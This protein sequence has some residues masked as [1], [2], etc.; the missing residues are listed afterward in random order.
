[1]SED[2]KPT[3]E[4]MAK[5]MLYQAIERALASVE[6]RLPERGTV[7]P[8]QVYMAEIRKRSEAVVDGLLEHMADVTKRMLVNHQA[9][10]SRTTTT[11][12]P[13]RED[14][15]MGVLH[16]ADMPPS[17]RRPFT[18]AMNTLEMVMRLVSKGPIEVVV[19]DEDD[20]V[21]RPRV[22]VV[23]HVRAM[24]W[25]TP[26]DERAVLTWSS[27]EAP[28]REYA[29]RV[30]DELVIDTVPCVVQPNGEIEVQEQAIRTLVDAAQERVIARA[31][32]EHERNG[33]PAE[34]GTV[35]AAM[36]SHVVLPPFDELNK[37]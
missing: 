4:P 3:M 22:L 24:P 31:R 11:R 33:R 30:G 28:E 20:V 5:R 27:C 8:P 32:E 16:L 29:F 7:V 25:G 18:R 36:L 35:M 12:L 23:A 1:M 34:T 9:A 10:A 17:V 13:E 14:G 21:K 6:V 2:V 26:A 19:E 37:E 15:S